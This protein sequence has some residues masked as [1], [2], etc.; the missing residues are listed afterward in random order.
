MYSVDDR[1]VVVE[2]TDVPASDPGAPLPVVVA[3]EG[4][5]FLAYFV[6]VRVPFWDGKSVRVV[7]A[8][9]RAPVAAVEFRGPHAHSLGPPNDEAFAGHPLASRGLRPYMAATVEASSWV[10]QLERM[11][12]VHPS[13]RPDKY[14]RLRHYV[15]AF[16][17]STFE[18]VAAAHAFTRRCPQDC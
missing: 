11:N 13:H 18:C 8:A 14:A 9:T 10:R 12:A 7:S 5:L 1:D 17:D 3:A 6:H 15:F 4:R 2:L 16:H